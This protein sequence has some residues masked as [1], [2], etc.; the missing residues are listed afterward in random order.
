MNIPAIVLAIL[1]LPGVPKALGTLHAHA[2]GQ[3]ATQEFGTAIE[4]DGRYR[5]IQGEIGELSDH[6]KPD[7]HT[8]LMAHTHPDG[9]N[10]M[11][12]K[13]DIAIARAT[14]IPDVVISRY[15]EYVAMPDGRVVRIQ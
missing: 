6:I 10:P 3:H 14:G 1:S 11:P 4:S 2:I 12:S 15:A 5:I 13:Q 9:S 8:V 7:S